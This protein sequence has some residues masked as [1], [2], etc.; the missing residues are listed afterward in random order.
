MVRKMEAKGVLY[1]RTRGKRNLLVLRNASLE[2]RLRARD[3]DCGPR[4]TASPRDGG[5][6]L[7]SVGGSGSVEG[8]KLSKRERRLVL[9]LRKSGGEM[10]DVSLEVRMANSEDVIESLI[11]KGEVFRWGAKRRNVCLVGY[12]NEMEERLVGLLRDNGGR[13]MWRDLVLKMGYCGKGFSRVLD[14]LERKGLIERRKVG[15]S[16]EV[17]VV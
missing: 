4:E 3:T 15:R 5:K 10:R 12:K 13:M 6:V 2:K 8:V 11:K 7:G 14:K 1:R 9:I 16:L 17:I